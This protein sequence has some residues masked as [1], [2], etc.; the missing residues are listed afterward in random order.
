MVTPENESDPHADAEGSAEAASAGPGGGAGAEGVAGAGAARGAGGAGAAAPRSAPS[1]LAVA[2]LASIGAGAIHATAVGV[3]G[4]HRQTAVA[5]VVVALFQIGWGVLALV[6]S[7]ARVGLL[8]A[9]GNAVALGGWVMAKTSGIG[10]VDGLEQAESVQFTDAL[11][12]G[13]AAVAVLGSLAGLVGRLGW[14][15][16][17]QPVLMGVS[18]VATLGLALPAMVVAGDHD[19]AGGGGHG[20]HEAAG[21]DDHDDHDDGHGGHEAAVVPP[22]PFDGTLPV[23]LSGAEGVASEEQ[24]DAEALLT[25]TIE[26]LPQFADT[27]TAYDRGYRSIGDALTGVEHYVNWRYVDDDKLLDPDYPESLVYEVDGDER[28]LVAAMYMLTSEDT[29]ETVP[30][31]GGPLIQWH[32]HEDLCYM[33]EENAWTLGDVAMPP[34]EC[35]PGTFHFENPAPMMHAWIVPHPCGPFAAL[36]GVG[37]GQIPEG[38]ERACDHAHGDP[39]ATIEEEGPPGPPGPPGGAESAQGG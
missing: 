34:E 29:L 37:G 20:D 5:F 11:A 18:V 23:D 22:E 12:A 2:A 31:I 8:G 17:P 7:R 6:R 3:H 35:R 21:G 10:F 9:A 32:V 30:D 13:F 36:E 27:Q 15:R 38:E 26:R 24:A 1:G 28:T 39:S 14:A 19:H 33:G 25:R 4:E 16:S